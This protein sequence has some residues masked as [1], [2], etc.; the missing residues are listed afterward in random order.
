MLEEREMKM[1]AILSFLVLKKKNKAPKMS[2]S[3]HGDVVF[4]PKMGWVKGL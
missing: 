3:T 4:S 1:G 2:L